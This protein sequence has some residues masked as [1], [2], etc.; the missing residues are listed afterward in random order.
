MER[1]AERL[2]VF[3]ELL[4]STE[5]IKNGRVYSA[6]NV[7]KHMEDFLRMLEKEAQ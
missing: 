6:E 7:K 2:Y 5:D 3:G 4:K 1:E